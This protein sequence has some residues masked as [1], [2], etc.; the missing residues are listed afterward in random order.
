VDDSIAKVTGGL[1]TIYS[2]HRLK[3]TPPRPDARPFTVEEQPERGWVV[4]RS[5]AEPAP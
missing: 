1:L 5:E 3:G 2:R 4:I